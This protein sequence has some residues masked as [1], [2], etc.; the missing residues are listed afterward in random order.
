MIQERAFGIV[1]ICELSGILY[2]RHH[3]KLCCLQIFVASV[4]LVHKPFNLRVP[5]LF[6]QD[7]HIDS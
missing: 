3:V 5:K 2:L 4:L 1:S 6:L 7:R